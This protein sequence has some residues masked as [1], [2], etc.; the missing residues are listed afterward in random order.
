M[1][2]ASTLAKDMDRKATD[3]YKLQRQASKYASPIPLQHH[4]GPSSQQPD[5]SPEELD[6]LCSEFYRR[7]VLV[8]AEQAKAI[9]RATRQQSDSPD[10]YRHRRVRVTASNFGRIARRRDTTPVANLIKSLLYS[11]PVNAPSLRWGTTHENDARKSILAGDG[12][13]WLQRSYN[14]SIWPGN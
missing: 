3:E 8:T 4:Y 1:K 10:W 5:V 2:R 11:K 9:E 13:P 7:E 6:R 14:H 12:N